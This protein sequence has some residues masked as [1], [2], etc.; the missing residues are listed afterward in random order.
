LELLQV[1]SPSLPVGS[2]ISDEL[3]AERLQSDPLVSRVS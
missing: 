3:T 2:W 1:R